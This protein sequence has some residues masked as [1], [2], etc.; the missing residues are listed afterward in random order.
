M[1]ATYIDLYQKHQIHIAEKDGRIKLKEVDITDFAVKLK[2]RRDLP[3]KDTFRD[4]IRRH[5]DFLRNIA[6]ENT[7]LSDLIDKT[8][9][10]TFI[11]GVAGMGKSV[12][13]KQLACAWSHNKMYT[14]FKLCIVFECREINTFQAT[15]GAHFK[16]HEL[17]EEF[18][19][20]KFNYNL[21]DGKGILFVVDGLDELFDIRTDN[22]IIKQLLCRKIYPASKVVITGRPHVES[23]LEECG[24]IGGLQKVEIQGLSDKQIEEYVNKF[25]SPQ[26]FQ[27]DLSK[28]KDSSNR[29]LPVMHVPQ[30]LNTF[31][32]VAIL[33]KEE[34]I[35]NGAELYCWTIYLLLKQHGD[36][37]D[38]GKRKLIT[39]IFREYSKE[40]LTLGEL[41]HKLLYENKLIIFKEDIER[42]LDGCGRGKEF[43]DSFFVDVSD[44]F[45]RK[46][47]FKH[48]TLMEFFAAFH[49]CNIENPIEIIKESLARGFLE[50]VVFTCQLIAGV[51]CRLIVK[52]MVV[53]NAAELGQVNWSV[54]C[55]DV[56]KALQGC[57]F[58]E[59]TAFMNSLDVI[60]LFLSNDVADREVFISTVKMLKSKDLDLNV[61]NSR[62]LYHIYEY[63]L[64]K[65]R[66]DENDIRTAFEHIRFRW[67]N[68][69]DLEIIHCVQYFGY[70]GGIELNDMQL[71][72]SS[73]MREFGSLSYGKGLKVDIWSCEIEDN[74]IEHQSYGL[75]LDVLGIIKCKLKNVNSL[76]NAF[77]WVTLSLSSSSFES[78]K[79]LQLWWLAT[80]DGWWSEL[81]KVIEL[82]KT[83]IGYSKLKKL[84]MYECTPRMSKELQMRVSRFTSL[85]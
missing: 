79:V 84:D 15:R 20:T 3:P 68:V 10:V 46:L 78:C 40:L 2:M 41:C 16:N 50:V 24:E 58:D 22:S 69:N 62:K 6:S 5:L 11:R 39:D 23:K 26:G 66:C 72:I 28:A 9:R 12:L 59:K 35:K 52:E 74:K 77:H 45:T 18:V 76:I 82:E 30:F 73:V 60:V 42:L 37:Q 56:V 13:S 80:Q 14:D 34:T 57:K 49:I 29:F 51:K 19:K 36:K 32:C 4:E 47:Q 8:N 33:L 38:A 27:V 54:F 17:L 55:F 31:C 44:D 64:T 63:L 83:A 1:K 48:L 81:V 25:L 67:L 21:E 7:E 85:L 75:K 53:L 65:C 43:I 61:E 70:V 71:N